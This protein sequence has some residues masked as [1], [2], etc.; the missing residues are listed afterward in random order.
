MFCKLFLCPLSSLIELILRIKDLY[1][2]C[3]VQCKLNLNGSCSAAGSKYDGLLTF[4]IKTVQF[5]VL[6]RKSVV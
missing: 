5:K 1:L 6:D 4:Y 2:F 3:P